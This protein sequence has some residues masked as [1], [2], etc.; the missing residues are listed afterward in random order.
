MSWDRKHIFLPLIL[1]LA[2]PHCLRWLVGETTT[3]VL[4]VATFALMATS[5]RPIKQ[6]RTPPPFGHR[7]WLGGVLLYA[8]TCLGL[9]VVMPVSACRLV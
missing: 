9:L 6:G 8:S 2:L 7:H 1:K 4:V 5:C 3:S